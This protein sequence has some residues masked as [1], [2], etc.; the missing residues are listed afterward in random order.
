MDE[1]AIQ[2]L[3]S[4]KEKNF[5]D[6]SKEDLDLGDKDEEEEKQKKQEFIQTCDWI[7]KRL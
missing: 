7:K 3:K 1:L 2:N 5:V 6:I 4:Y